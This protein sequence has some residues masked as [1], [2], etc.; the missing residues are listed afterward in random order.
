M[1]EPSMDEL[2]IDVQQRGP[3]VIVKLAGS[4][5]MEVADE[6]QH[7]LIGLVDEDSGPV[8]LD[9]SELDFISSTGL[10]AIIAAHLRCRNGD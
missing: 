8:V 7:R 2:H 6:L 4:A 5:D 3:A 10:G 9:L 1:S